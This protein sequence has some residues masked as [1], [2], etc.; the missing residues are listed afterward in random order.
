MISRVLRGEAARGH[1]PVRGGEL[2]DPRPVAAGAGPRLGE[3]RARLPLLGADGPDRRRG[4]FCIFR[5]LPEN[6]IICT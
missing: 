3:P 4:N 1:A 5:N 2:Q 6:K